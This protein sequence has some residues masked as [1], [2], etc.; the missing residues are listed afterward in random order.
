M[1]KKFDPKTGRELTSTHGD[2]FIEWACSCPECTEQIK[3][4]EGHS[5]YSLIE[6]NR[7]HHG[8]HSI[9]ALAMNPC[10]VSNCHMAFPFEHDLWTHAEAAHP[11]EVH[12]LGI[13][14]A[15]LVIIPVPDAIH[16]IVHE[17]YEVPGHGARRGKKLDEHH[18]FHATNHA[19]VKSHF[20]G[21][22]SMNSKTA[23]DVLAG[24]ELPSGL[25]HPFGDN[26]LDG[27]YSYSFPSPHSTYNEE[28]KM[29]T[30]EQHGHGH[31]GN[32]RPHPK[33]I[34]CA[35][36]HTVPSGTML[37]HVESDTED[38]G[39]IFSCWHCGHY[40]NKKEEQLLQH[41]HK[42]HAEAEKHSNQHL[43]CEHAGCK[44]TC[45]N[46]YHK[47]LHKLL[48]HHDTAAQAEHPDSGH[49]GSS[50]HD[51]S[52]DPG[53]GK[54]HGRLD[55]HEKGP[56]GHEAAKD[57]ENGKNHSEDHSK[58]HTKADH[59]KEQDHLKDHNKD[60]TKADHGKEQDHSKDHAKDHGKADHGKE[61]D[62]PKG[63]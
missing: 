10:P 11:A 16:H 6:H 19:P 44:K 58:D 51:K 1:R 60:H 62:H 4:N 42:M 2:H 12:S 13:S 57:H 24:S 21:S 7:D 29:T 33:K 45:S 3:Q 5:V 15:T 48:T 8:P 38:H 43:P 49:S 52:H 34:E 56:Q 36:C 18:D 14:Q 50:E 28:N 63:H 41:I 26:K 22:Q 59:G 54:D 61:K 39:G 32:T 9:L 27:P 37:A 35:G 46:K 25:N 31:P 20:R 40:F 23:H 47:D 17:A 53:E 55:G 30:K